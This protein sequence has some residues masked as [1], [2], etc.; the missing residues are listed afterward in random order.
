MAYRLR[1][2]ES[3]TRGL[4]RLATKQLESARDELRQGTPPSDEAIHEARK[5][6][7]KVRAILALIETD[8]GKGVGRS[9]KRLR[10]VGHTLSALRDADAMLGILTKLR[11]RN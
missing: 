7:K 9:Q 1:P 11:S 8:D 5:S 3:V 2:D 6:I 4:R 10:A